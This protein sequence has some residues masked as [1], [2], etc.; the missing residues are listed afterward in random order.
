MSYGE[1]KQKGIEAPYELVINAKE[2][3]LYYF[4][5]AHSNDISHPQWPKWHEFWKDF[6][7]K[8]ENKKRIVFIEGNSTHLYSN[9]EEAILSA[10][11]MGLA[12][13]KAKQNNI[14]VYSPEPG[15]EEEMSEIEKLHPSEL[16]IYFYIARQV[17]QWGRMMEPKP[18]IEAYLGN[19]LKY[20]QTSFE[21][22]KNTH[23]ELFNKDFDQ[24]DTGFFHSI[25][26]PIFPER[27]VINTISQEV[28]NMR[29]RY[30]A[31]KIC[32]YIRNDLSVFAQFGH[33][34]VVMQEPL[35]RELLS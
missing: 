33:T 11:G 17:A 23:K 29:D 31:N 2:N 25:V 7:N 20:Y 15:R 21:A 16:V 34:H 3:H 32:E 28:N 24:N 35:L 27:S 10:G 4:G 9:E 14:E 18:G 22:V 26:D 13:L 19:Y 30:I 1:Y 8:T 5:E 6:L 12:V